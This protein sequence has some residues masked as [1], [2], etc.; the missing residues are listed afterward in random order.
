MEGGTD[1]GPPTGARE[2]LAHGPGGKG[3]K[4]KPGP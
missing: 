4:K 3:V 2:D 1:E